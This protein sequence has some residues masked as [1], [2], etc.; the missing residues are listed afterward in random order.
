MAVSEPLFHHRPGVAPN[1]TFHGFMVFV[2]LYVVTPLID[3]RLLHRSPWKESVNKSRMGNRENDYWVDHW[4]LRW[5]EILCYVPRR[6]LCSWVGIL[7][8]V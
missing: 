5:V 8:W 3:A 4:L 2:Y 6:G 7:S 1:T